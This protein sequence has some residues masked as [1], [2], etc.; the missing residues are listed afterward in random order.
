MSST[1][2]VIK[3][4][5]IIVIVITHT[6]RHT[7]ILTHVHTHIDTQTY[8]HMHT[9]TVISKMYTA[10]V[11]S[12]VGGFLEA[13]ELLVDEQNGFRPGRSCVDHIF[14]LHDLL[15]IRKS[16]GMETFC[17]F[18]DFQKAFDCGP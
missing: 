2:L 4:V 7:D 11:G 1:S 3:N 6:H 12:R 18:I 13:N 10:L 9:H 8:L 15:R 17:T 5:I 14:A 16:K